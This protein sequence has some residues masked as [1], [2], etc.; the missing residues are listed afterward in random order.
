MRMTRV[1]IINKLYK[2]IYDHSDINKITGRL[3]SDES[4]KGVDLV[5]E[6]IKKCMDRVGY[7]GELLIYPVNGG[8]RKSQ[9]GMSEWKQYEVE[10]NSADDVKE[11]VGTLNCHTGGTVNDPFEKYDMSLV[12]SKV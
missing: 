11:L 4:W 5:R 12:I 7:D 8:Y 2:E 6:E 1:K 3:Y 9:D 10:I